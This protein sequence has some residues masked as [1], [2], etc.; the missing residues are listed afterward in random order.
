M[1]DSNS[2]QTKIDLL[3]NVFNH[4]QS[5]SMKLNSIS[6]MMNELTIVSQLSVSEMTS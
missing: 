5:L 1:S 4:L 6:I 3:I 2:N